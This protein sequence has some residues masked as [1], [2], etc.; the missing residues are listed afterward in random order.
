MAE[1]MTA[2]R[3]G[4][5]GRRWNRFFVWI[6]LAMLGVIALGF[7]RSF[8]L[9]PVF[10]ESSLPLLLVVH[11]TI[12]TL[13]YL[14]FLAQAILASRG[15]L[16]LHRRLGIAG[17]GLALAVVVSGAQVH[18]GNVSR[19]QA[20]GLVLNPETLAAAVAFTLEGL[21]F[22]LPFVVLIALAVWLRRNP[23]SHKRLMF[24]AMAW[25][26]GP[27]LSGTRPLGQFLDPLVAPY[28]PFFPFDLIWL[29]ALMAY[30]WKTLRRI[31]PATWLGFGSL[32]AY[33][34][35]ITPWIVSIDALHVWLGGYL[36]RAG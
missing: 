12:M 8:Y 28:L 7:G 21:L 26:L 25:T 35:V 17:I 29:A 18:L 13:W 20:S 24:W 22:L 10:L 34:L 19:W 9:R 15:S 32:A 1:S 36:S 2:E 11:G 6:A 27:A 30:D 3:V 31:H 14:V 23:A 4:S 33:F 5:R 16:R